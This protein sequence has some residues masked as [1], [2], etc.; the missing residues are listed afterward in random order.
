MNL[1]ELIQL[2]RKYTS[3]VTFAEMAEEDILQYARRQFSPEQ[4]LIIERAITSELILDAKKCSFSRQKSKEKHSFYS[5]EYYQRFHQKYQPV[6]EQEVIHAAENASIVYVA[7]FH[8]LKAP[9]TAFLAILNHLISAG[10]N[11]TTALE[12][13]PAQKQLAVEAYVNG[14][15]EKPPFDQTWYKPAEL[16]SQIIDTAKQNTPKTKILA[17]GPEETKDGDFTTSDKQMAVRIA[18]YYSP[19]RITAVFAGDYH[20][21]PSHLPFQINKLLGRQNDIIIY[22]NSTPL[23]WHQRTSSKT[24]CP[25]VKLSDNEFCLFN[26]TP[27]VKYQSA[28]DELEAGED[29]CSP[30]QKAS[31]ILAVTYLLCMLQNKTL[32]DKLNEE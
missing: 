4:Q 3:F 8:P 6:D 17:I 5:K 13:L 26:T 12:C 7:D 25:A 16:F 23:Y 11:I 30:E 21:A 29:D 22:Q 10:K 1:D 32:F 20:T 2:K 15:R 28:L 24:I 14:R 27:V 31:K 19:D 9:K 18:K